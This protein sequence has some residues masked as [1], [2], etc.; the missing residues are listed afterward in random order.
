VA[1]REPDSLKRGEG[2]V[3]LR[4]ELEPGEPL[5]GSI[6]IAGQSEKRFCGWIELMAAVNAARRRAAGEDETP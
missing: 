5:T 1:G 6:A 4:V 3:V 2:G